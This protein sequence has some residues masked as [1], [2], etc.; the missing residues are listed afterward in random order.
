MLQKKGSRIIIL[1]TTLILSGCSSVKD[2]EY[3]DPGKYSDLASYLNEVFEKSNC[4]GTIFSPQ[5]HKFVNSDGLNYQLSGRNL[6][7]YVVSIEESINRYCTVKRGVMK[8]GGTWCVV[9][10]SPLFHVDYSPDTS[11]VS[12]GLG[13]D[14]FSTVEP[15]ETLSGKQW[16]NTAE[17]L[18]Y[19]SARVQ[20]NIDV[21]KEIE[22]S[23]EKAVKAMRDIQMNTPVNANIGDLI[24]RDDYEVKSNQYPGTAYYKAYVEKK[25]KNKLQLRLVWHGGDGFVIND[26]TN[27]NNIIWSSPNG[28][29]HCN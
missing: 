18:G 16:L 13:S 19:I 15:P 3:V 11:M 5:G 10:D 27:V 21:D 8:Q 28:W 25:E 22:A 17:K 14:N 6:R 7:C 23:K 12:T 24:C 20:H 9:G 2:V 4:T 1:L 26:L 29:R